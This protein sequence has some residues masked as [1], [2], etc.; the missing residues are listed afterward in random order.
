M[1]KS[2]YTVG[3]TGVTK[4][5][6]VII[7]RFLII[8][9]ILTGLYHFILSVSKPDFFTMLT[10]RQVNLLYH[11]SGYQT[12]VIVLD[13]PGEIGIMDNVRWFV[14]IIE[15]CNGMSV[16]LF[17]LAFIFAFPARPGKK[18]LYAL[19]SSAVLWIINLIRIYIL[20][21]VYVYHIRYFDIFHRVFFPAIIY[22]SLV[23]IWF[24]WIKML[25]GASAG[26][27]YK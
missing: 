7:L 9:F 21:M 14:K 4:K 1:N 16:I 2:T 26:N 15:G 27:G 25:T 12:D 13:N 22:A 6:L 3:G 18:V 20:G 17:N 23:L 5:L 11:L 8:Y 10:A 24:V 19:V